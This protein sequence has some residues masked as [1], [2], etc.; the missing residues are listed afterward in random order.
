MPAH[1]IDVT[2]PA[3]AGGSVRFYQTGTLIQ[4]NVYSNDAATVVLTQPI[5]LDADGKSGSPVYTIAPV[6]A[7]FFDSIGAQVL[8]TERDNGERAEIVSLV[9]T[10]WPLSPNVNTALTNLAIS[11]GSTDGNSKPSFS[12]GVARSVQA[13]LQDEF[14][15]KDFG[16]KGNG[17]TLD[18][19]AFANAINAVALTGKAGVLRIPFGTYLLSNSLNNPVFAQ[20]DV[21]L[22]GDGKGASI[23]MANGFTTSNFITNVSTS[24][25]LNIRDLSVANSSVSTGVGITAK[26]LDN[27]LFFNVDISGF[28]TGISFDGTCTLVS[29]TTDGDAASSAFLCNTFSFS[30]FQCSAAA[31][32]GSGACVRI[33]SG[34]GGNGISIVDCDLIASSQTSVLFESGNSVTGG[35]IAGNAVGTTAIDASAGTRGLPGVRV[36]GNYGLGSYKILENAASADIITNPVAGTLTL[37]LSGSRFIKSTIIAATAITFTTASAPHHD[38][39]FTLV[40]QNST[41]GG[42]AISAGTGVTLQAGG[43]TVAAT[44]QSII[45]M[46][47]DSNASRLV[48]V[49]APLATA[50]T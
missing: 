22:Q 20:N 28:R 3:A 27:A 47:Y 45:H 15:V 16:A 14:N 25:A 37:A 31:T 32:A 4:E 43:F 19:N 35:V 48:Q 17:V 29:V 18:D 13:R 36:I 33:P 23:L 11:L 46:Q 24:H 1:F 9:N 30:M 44:S 41:G 10:Y 26:I 39:I 7:V 21:T 42:F 8:D 40:L 2:N 49:T 34:M 50:V 5:L 12:G 6:R 38:A